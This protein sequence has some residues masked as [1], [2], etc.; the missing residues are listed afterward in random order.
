MISS[1]SYLL[2]VVLAVSA[3]ASPLSLDKRLDKRADP[4]GIDVSDFTTGVN[5]KNV[6]S[7]GIDFVYIKA[8]E[9]TSQFFTSDHFLENR[10]FAYIQL[11][12]QQLSRAVCST[13]SLRTPQMQ[14]LSGGP[15]TSHTQTSRVEQ[16]R[17][18]FSL[19]ME[20]RNARL[21][22]PA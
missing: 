1:W 17:Q 21:Y 3:L 5:F 9:G 8:T 13:L 18:T 19:L 2:A 14:V 20:V 6:K 10:N 4:K 16:L 11:L 22:V 15:I 12:V 7:N